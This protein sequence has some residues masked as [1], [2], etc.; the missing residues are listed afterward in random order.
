MKKLIL[1]SVCVMFAASAALADWDPGD[2]HKMHY[3]Q[4]P[5]PLGWDVNFTEPKILA[6]DWRCSSSGPVKDIH[7]WFSSRYDEP[8][9]LMNIHVS[10]HEDVPAGGDN[11]TYSHPGN[12][13]W[14]ADFDPSQFTV[15]DWGSGQQGWYDPNPPVVV[16][17]FDHFLIYQA[18]IPRIADPFI[19]EVGKIYWLDLSVYAIGPG[20]GQLGWKTS[21]DH[22]MDDAVWSD[23]FVAGDAIGDVSGW[24]ELRDP[25]TGE[26]L[27]M[28]FVIT[29]EPATLSV[30]VLGAMGIL[31]RRRRR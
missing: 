16:Q 20:G 18:N 3:P 23:A 19:Q 5:D 9:Q 11:G 2:G 14:E 25:F 10:I 12:L 31:A 27:D 8:F 1:T 4:M 21:R 26:S 17:P 15:R 22:F 6:D 30:L 29:P 7:F 28:A 24:N 13:L